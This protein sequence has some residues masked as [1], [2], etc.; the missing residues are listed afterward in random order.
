MEQV[1][2]E[3]E[4]LKALDGKNLFFEEDLNICNQKL[5]QNLDAQF[6]ILDKSF[7]LE[8]LILQERNKEFLF[9]VNEKQDYFITP[10]MLLLATEKNNFEIFHFLMKNLPFTTSTLNFLN[11][12]LI[13]SRSIDR[14]DIFAK[15]NYYR[16]TFVD[17]L[18]VLNT[19][20]HINGNCSEKSITF[21]FAV[22]HNMFD[23]RCNF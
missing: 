10:N 15:V 12:C 3:A 11:L 2:W 21:L 6:E 1:R 23:L 7:F 13:K 18:N 20:L 14:P 17:C 22:A 8:T 9:L 4:V 19:Y 5:F 16:N